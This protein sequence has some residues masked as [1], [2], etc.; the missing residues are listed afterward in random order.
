MSKPAGP[1]VHDVGHLGQLGIGQGGAVL[2]FDSERHTAELSSHIVREQPVYVFAS[3]SKQG[4][5]RTS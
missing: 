2:R 1:S 5:G 3:L 4:G